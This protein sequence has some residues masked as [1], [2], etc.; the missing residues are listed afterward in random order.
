MRNLWVQFKIAYAA[1][2]IWTPRHFVYL[3]ALEKSTFCLNNAMLLRP[4]E[5]Q[6]CQSP[7]WLRKW[8]FGPTL[9]C[10]NA[11]LHISINLTASEPV[12]FSLTGHPDPF[13]KSSL[14]WLNLVT[15]VYHV[16]YKHKLRQH[17]ATLNRGIQ[18]RDRRKIATY[19]YTKACRRCD[20]CGYQNEARGNTDVKT[21][22]N[23]WM[24]SLKQQTKTDE[25]MPSMAVWQIITLTLITDEL[26]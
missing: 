5:W 16:Q 6:Y 11:L 13:S 3:K 14:T 18:F 2:Y 7:Q 8:P 24:L 9:C 23:E 10:L 21:K 22:W 15:L 19:W 12:S 4:A 26:G 25:T 20:F 1:K 17:A